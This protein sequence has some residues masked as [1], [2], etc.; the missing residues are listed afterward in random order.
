[1]EQRRIFW[2]RFRYPGTVYVSWSRI[3]IL[4]QDRIAWSRKGYPGARYYILYEG[5]LREEV[6]RT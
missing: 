4:G 1:M 6:S 5:R 3:H 2:S